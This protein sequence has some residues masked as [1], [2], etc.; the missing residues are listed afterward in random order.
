ML[1]AS[2][3][4]TLVALG[5]ASKPPP[6]EAPPAKLSAEEEIIKVA[7]EWRALEQA[8]GARPAPS[9]V[10]VFETSI[11]TTLTLT[12]GQGTG[13][14]R[15]VVEERFEMRDG[16]RFECKSDQSSH[17]KVRYGRHAGDPALEVSRPPLRLSRSCTPPDFYEPEIELGAEGSRFLLQDEQL[18]GFV[19]VGEK[20]VFLPSE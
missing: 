16:R 14:E 19:P 13:V 18:V 17:V 2:S 9:E 1:R 5:C 8:H 3:L 10:S 7:K 4:L 6:A 15:V 20:R 12:Q 11:Q